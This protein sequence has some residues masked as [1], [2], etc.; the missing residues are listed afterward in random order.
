MMRENFDDDLAA[1]RA[2]AQVLRDGSFKIEKRIKFNCNRVMDSFNEFKDWLTEFVTTDEQASND[3]LLEKVKRVDG[4]K[5]REK[6]DS[7]R[8]SVK[9][10]GDEKTRCALSYRL[11]KAVTNTSTIFSKLISS[12]TIRK[13]SFPISRNRPTSERANRSVSTRAG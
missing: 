11:F 1:D 12:L 8:R 5:T 3:R 4:R 6:E 9:T 7:L 13:D 2:V 10:A